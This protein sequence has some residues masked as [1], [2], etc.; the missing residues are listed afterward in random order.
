MSTV[1]YKTSVKIYHSEKRLDVG[2]TFWNW[3]FIDSIYFG[4]FNYDT[5][6]GLDVTQVIYCGKAKCALWLLSIQLMPPQ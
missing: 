4:R 3:P 6:I 5:Q 1:L 2:F